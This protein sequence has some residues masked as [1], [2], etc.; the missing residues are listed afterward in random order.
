L[1]RLLQDRIDL[2]RQL[3][4]ADGA[5]VSPRDPSVPVKEYRYRQSPRPE[6][7]CYAIVPSD[8]KGDPVG[9]R[10]LP[11]VLVTALDKDAGKADAPIAISL[12]GFLKI[13]GL[14]PALRSPVGADVDHRRRAYTGSVG[15]C[16]SVIG[17][18]REFFDRISG[19]NRCGKE[20]HQCCCA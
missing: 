7:P 11:Y 2:R 16:L 15:K 4:K 14:P 9:L 19:I 3:R 6:Y 1:H 12:I 17:P 18:E 8:R 20:K 10:E 13:R 5:Y